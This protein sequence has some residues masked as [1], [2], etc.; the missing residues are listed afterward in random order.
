MNEENKPLDHLSYKYEDPYVVCDE[1]EWR[2]ARPSGEM[3]CGLLAKQKNPHA[4]VI[5]W[6]QSRRG[7]PQERIALA[8]N[9]PLEQ[10]NEK[11]LDKPERVVL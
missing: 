1:C 9:C 6:R 4:F 10:K 7:L 3:F 11:K 5:S 8:K 2:R